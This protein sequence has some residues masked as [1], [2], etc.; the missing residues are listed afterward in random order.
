MHALDNVTSLPPSPHQG[1][2]L[3]VREH[4]EGGFELDEGRRRIVAR[5]AASC[6]LAPAAGDRVWVVG[7]AAS[8]FYVIAVLERG[9]QAPAVVALPG[10]ATIRAEGTLTMAG[11]RG[12]Q[13]TTPHGLGV[14]A[15][16]L[17]VQANKGTAVVEEL[18]LI[19]RSVFAS[20]TRVTRVGKVLELFVD[21]FVQR[22]THS[23]RS[24]EGLD[25][26][27]AQSI[28]YRADGDAHIQATHALVNGKNLVKMDGGQ[29]HL[30]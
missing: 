27:Q 11:G 4:P 9:E 1:T 20:L 30:G 14:S 24:I 10:D 16:E 22:S 15:G 2:A 5:R 17:D 19:A 26:T 6:L 28:D 7:D 12:L 21:R 25:R 8:G 13:V 3:V 18:S 29:I 23:V